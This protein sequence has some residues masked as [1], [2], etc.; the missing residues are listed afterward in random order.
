MQNLFHL[1]LNAQL[2]LFLPPMEEFSLITPRYCCR[3][4]LKFG[5]KT[6]FFLLCLRAITK[7]ICLSSLELWGCIPSVAVNFITYNF[8][9]ATFYFVVYVI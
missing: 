7:K 8:H 5:N 9:R 4:I 1:N 3:R 6:T 2:S